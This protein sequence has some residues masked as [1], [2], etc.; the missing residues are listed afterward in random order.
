MKIDV[1]EVTRTPL[2]TKVRLTKWIG[3]HEIDVAEVTQNTAAAKHG[4]AQRIGHLEKTNVQQAPTIV[5][6]MMTQKSAPSR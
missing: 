2:R 1:A 3:H 6:T 5:K 4:L